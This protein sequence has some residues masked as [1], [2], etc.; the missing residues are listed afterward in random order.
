MF[1]ES[2][3]LLLDFLHETQMDPRLID[4]ITQYREGR[5][6]VKMTDIARNHVHF[7]AFAR[8]IDSLGWDCFLEGR[9]PASIMVLQEM[10]LQS[11]NSY[12][13]IKTWA[14][15]LRCNTCST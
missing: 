9:V 8:D 12:W 6:K 2:A 15:H 1:Y 14:S 3:D 11:T 5:G 13:K 4:C 7:D 10:Y